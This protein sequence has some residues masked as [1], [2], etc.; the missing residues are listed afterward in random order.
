MRGRKTGG[1]MVI[2]RAFP[3]RPALMCAGIIPA[4]MHTLQGL[5]RRAGSPRWNIPRCGP[6]KQDG[7]CIGAQVRG[8]AQPGGAGKKRDPGR[9]RR[10]YPLRINLIRKPLRERICMAWRGCPYGK[11]G[12]PSGGDRLRGPSPNC[13]ETSCAD[14]PPHHQRRGRA[15]LTRYSGARL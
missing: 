2:G 6:I 3:A 5:R 4:I 1:Y 13:S 15:F 8:A 12:F 7:A 10:E 11:Y 9:M 14:D